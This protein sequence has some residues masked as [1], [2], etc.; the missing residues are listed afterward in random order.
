VCFIVRKTILELECAILITLFFFKQE[1]PTFC[2][3]T[4]VICSV[5]C[6]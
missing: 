4:R 5:L 2:V 1:T 3:P 6:L